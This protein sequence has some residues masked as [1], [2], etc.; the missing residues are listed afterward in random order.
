MAVYYSEGEREGEKQ[1]IVHL[2]CH[3]TL[4]RTELSHSNKLYMTKVACRLKMTSWDSMVIVLENCL[5]YLMALWL[6][7]VII[8]S[9]Q[10]VSSTRIALS[11]VQQIKLLF[12][13]NLF[14]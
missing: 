7:F 11:R 1:K 6:W 13:L 2:F 9:H 3:Y 14:L 12:I 8:D 5:Q 4:P 10:A